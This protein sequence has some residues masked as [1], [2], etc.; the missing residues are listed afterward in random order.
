MPADYVLVRQVSELSAVLH[1][2]T[3][4]GDRTTTE[5]Q[6]QSFTVYK[7][8]NIENGWSVP[9]SKRNILLWVLL[10]NVFLIKKMINFSFFT[11][12]HAELL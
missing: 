4:W 10:E 3:E 8:E 5:D 9:L 7:Y 2:D 11:G 12:N 1:W 6:L